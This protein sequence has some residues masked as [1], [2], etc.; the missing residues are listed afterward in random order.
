MS[1]NIINNNEI[2]LSVRTKLNKGIQSVNSLNELT[3]SVDTRLGS[4]ETESGSIRTDFTNFTSSID[5]T[6][7]AKLNEDSILSG[8]LLQVKTFLELQNV[9]NTADINKPLSNPQKE[10]VDEVAQGLTSRPSAKVATTTNLSA[11]YDN[12]V[13]GSG[14]TLTSTVSQSLD[15]VGIDGINTFFI[16]DEILV[17]NQLSEFENGIYIV[18]D[19]GSVS[20]PWELTR[21]TFDDE[22][23][24]VPGSFVF[25]TSGSVNNN[26]GWVLTVNDSD[27]FT[28]GTDDINVI[29]FS[30]AGT[31]TAGNALNLSGSEF[32]V[33]ESDITLSELDGYGSYTSSVDSDIQQVQTNLEN[34]TG[35]FNTFTS[36]Y[37]TGS[38]TGS[39]TGDGSGLTNLPDAGGGLEGT[40]YV[41]VS[42]N[43]TDTENAQELQDAYDLAKTKVSTSQESQAISS[44][45]QGFEK[46]NGQY[47]IVVDGGL[48]N[49]E[50]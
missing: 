10:Y 32:N 30:G 25:V 38:F 3:S 28:I 20:N 31:Y 21:A 43:G 18:T 50:V 11:T 22:S 9:D 27:S 13:S 41:F 17:K 7:K 2:G 4:L 44:F 14:A 19:T 24:E 35:S 29:Q 8:S 36:S 6:I 46:S 48:S 15:S 45:D 39:F 26:T 16:D 34:L 37:N 47:E 1:I 40:D 12:G 5:T 42:A 23:N 33:V 49:F